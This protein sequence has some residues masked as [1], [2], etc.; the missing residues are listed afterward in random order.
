MKQSHKFFTPLQK[1][2][3]KTFLFPFGVQHVI[4]E[5]IPHLRQK[6]Y[7]YYIYLPVAGILP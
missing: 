1:R 7:D 3:K 5:F 4:E 2:W 6:R